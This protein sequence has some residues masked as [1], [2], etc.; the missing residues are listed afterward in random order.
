MVR[1][2]RLTVFIVLISLIGLYVVHQNSIM[3]GLSADRDYFVDFAQKNGITYREAGPSY[4]HRFIITKN[5]EQF[6][7]LTNTGRKQ[8]LYINYGVCHKIESSGN[9]QSVLGELAERYRTC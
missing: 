5:G 6:G 7:F 3:N 9:P 2:Y 8:Q 1:S 4:E